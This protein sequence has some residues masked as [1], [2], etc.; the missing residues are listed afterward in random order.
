MPIKEVAKFHTFSYE[1]FCIHYSDV[2]NENFVFASMCIFDIKL[3]VSS[4][5]FVH[6]VLTFNFIPRKTPSGKSGNFHKV[7]MGDVLL[8]MS[9][10]NSPL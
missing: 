5:C 3:F 1:I 10:I 9:K 4:S 6:N 8:F 7:P 2:Q